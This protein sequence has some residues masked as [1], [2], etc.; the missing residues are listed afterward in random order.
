MEDIRDL[1]ENQTLIE[2]CPLEDKVQQQQA[3]EQTQLCRREDW[4]GV[5]EFTVEYV[6]QDSIEKVGE[7]LILSVRDDCGISDY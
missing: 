1:D 7:Q 6:S 5:K 4:S 3:E 2:N